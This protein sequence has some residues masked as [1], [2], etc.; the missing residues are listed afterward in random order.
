MVA[1]NEGYVDHTYKDVV[2]V[3][4][5]GFGETKNVKMGEK[6]DVVRSLRVLEDSMNDHAKGMVSCIKVPISQGEFDAYLDFTYNV[7]VGNFC[8]STLNQKLNAGQYDAACQ[9]LL[10]W[11]RAG[12]RVI[13]AL[14]KRRQ[15]EYQICSG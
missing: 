4:T 11:N 7:G 3:P 8:S 6:T 10:R 2:G 5:I 9:E 12:G 14:T 1:S 13:P 15:E